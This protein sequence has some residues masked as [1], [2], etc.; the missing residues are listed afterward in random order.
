MHPQPSHASLEGYEELQQLRDR[1]L[2]RKRHKLCP[3]IEQ[4][5]A[6]VADA[7]TLQSVLDDLSLSRPF[8]NHL[9]NFARYKVLSVG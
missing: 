5:V 1:E 2:Y 6:L 4:G 8:F 3:T 7:V 9:D